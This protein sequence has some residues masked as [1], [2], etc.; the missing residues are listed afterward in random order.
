MRG[1]LG[2]EQLT[3]FS[4]TLEQ[5]SSRLGGPPAPFALHAG[6]AVGAASAGGAYFGGGSLG[7]GPPS[8]DG[9]RMTLS[10]AASLNPAASLGFGRH[11]SA[12]S[13]G[14]AGG[15]WGGSSSSMADFNERLSQLGS[16]R[17]D[18]LDF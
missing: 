12:S 3:R 1:V 14:F 9:S 18:D 13:G 17:I 5:G 2:Q 8:L 6:S 16:G 11:A 10:N 15:Q 7:S 4:I